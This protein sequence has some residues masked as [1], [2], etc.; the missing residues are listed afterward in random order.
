MN[1]SSYHLQNI[2]PTVETRK[3][4][5]I[6]LLINS[7]YE[8]NAI[9]INIIRS[10]RHARP[11]NNNNYSTS[12][13]HRDERAAA[14]S[15]QLEN[16]PRGNQL[17]IIPFSELPRG[18]FTKR[19]IHSPTRARAATTVIRR[20]EACTGAAAVALLIKPVKYSARSRARER[21]EKAD[22]TNKKVITRADSPTQLI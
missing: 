16:F 22:A 13:S 1:E 19:I 18:G 6:Y 5:C 12:A 10:P 21:R 9:S 3:K 4:T 20:N 15:R 7:I 8:S 14:Q 17:T 2:L 11:T